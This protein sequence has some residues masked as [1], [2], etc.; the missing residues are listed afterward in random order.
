MLREYYL[1]RIMIL[2]KVFHL[3]EKAVFL[4]LNTLQK[5]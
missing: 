4:I 2:K 5:V 1:P 3:E